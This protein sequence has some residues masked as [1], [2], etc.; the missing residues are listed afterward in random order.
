MFTRHFSPPQA[1]KGHARKT[2]W[3]GGGGGGG[4]GEDSLVVGPLCTFLG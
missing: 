3:V 2:R 1:V 4:G